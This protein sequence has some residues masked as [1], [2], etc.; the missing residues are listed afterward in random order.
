MGTPCTAVRANELVVG[1]AGEL[2]KCWENVGDRREV[3]GHVRDYERQ[4]SRV[5]RWLAYDPFS[6]DECRNCIALPVCMGGC[7]HH[8]M[9]EIQHENRCD[10][11][12]HNYRERLGD[13]VEA[14]EESDDGR[15]VHVAAL[16]RRMD[17]R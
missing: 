6:D 7:A 13:F 2:Y 10:S 17:G 16:S 14:A 11:F 15:P 8:A 4:N 5:R 9:D 1:S 12:R 3:I